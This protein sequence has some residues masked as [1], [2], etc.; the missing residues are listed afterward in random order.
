MRILIL[1]LAISIVVNLI[2]LAV[3]YKYL[4]TRRQLGRVS[5]SL[6]Q[7]REE[8]NRR[9]RKQLLFIHHSV[10]ENWLNEGGLRD[11]LAG[12]GAGVHSAT[13]GS[14]IGQDTDM[15]DWVLKFDRYLDKMFKYDVRP[16]IMYGG[17][18]ENDIIMFKPCFPNSD[19]GGEGTP[20]GNPNDKIRT[21]WN[22]KS[23]FE[24]LLSRFEKSPGKLFIYITAP[25]LVPAETTPENAV[26]AR[27]FNNWVKND[28]VAE[29]DKRTNLKN[30]RVFDLFDV[31][32][33]SN[34]YLKSEYRRSDTNSHP[35]AEGGLEA[36]IRFMQFLRENHIPG[37][38]PQPQGRNPG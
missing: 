15:S 9:F 5:Q 28:F 38:E 19:I 34:N 3:A 14:V 33:D 23:V 31:L 35:N 29:Y 12:L 8:Y 17:D 6:I 1:I 22:Y 18:R 16:E 4:K 32:A 27:D 24:N 37:L 2:G 20:P 13:Y 25:P 10:G 11:S 7:T 36:T 21:I 26:R 30:F